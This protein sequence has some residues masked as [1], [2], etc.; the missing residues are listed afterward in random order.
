[1]PWRQSLRGSARRPT[2]RAGRIVA[3]MGAHGGCGATAIATQV[4]AFWAGKAKTC[5]IDLDVQFGAAALYLDVRPTLSLADIVF[6]GARLDSELF[7]QVAVTHATG[8][9]VIAAPPETPP[10]DLLGSGLMDRMLDIARSRYDAVVLDLP[11]A[12]I[13][14]SVRAMDRADLLLLVTTLSVAGIHQARRHM[15]VLAENNLT[16][17]MRLVANRVEP[18]LIG[19][20]NLKEPERL[21]G[22]PIGAVIANEPDTMGAALDLGR[23]IAASRSKGRLEK[24]L[25][26]LVDM[27]SQP[28][29]SEA[30]R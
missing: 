27:V 3:V 12:W 10:L 26:A 28:L 8:L 13:D 25:R 19:K 23:P 7:D 6:A 4:A 11:R 2:R 1:M 16:D 20:P 21:L 9:D 15:A 18:P 29:G 22:H 24:D 17:K 30:A 14:W 5:L